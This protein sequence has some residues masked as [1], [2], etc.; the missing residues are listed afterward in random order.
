[1]T[2]N[3]SVDARHSA[4]DTHKKLA[5]SYVRKSSRT[6]LCC[7]CFRKLLSR[8]CAL[9][10]YARC[11]QNTASRCLTLPHTVPQAASPCLTLPRTRPASR[12]GS[13]CLA[14]PHAA[15]RCPTLH[16]P[17]VMRHKCDDVMWPLL[18]SHTTARTDAPHR[19][20]SPPARAVCIYARCN[21]MSA[22]ASAVHSH[23]LDRPCR[24][25]SPINSHLL[26]GVERFAC[27]PARNLSCPL[28]LD[29]TSP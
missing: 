2:R 20:Y 23:T 10:L 5:R 3:Q 29:A 28:P 22:F 9:L 16:A 27:S 8:H 12:S 18:C 6:H 11:T 4:V 1:M 13:R 21:L 19:F 14:L 7:A 24:P 15:P 25:Y 17:P 26:E